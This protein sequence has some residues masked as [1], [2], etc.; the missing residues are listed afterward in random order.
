MTKPKLIVPKH[1]WDGAQAEK[2]KN[3]LEKIPQPSGWR[4]VLFPLKLQGKTKGG[5]L[6]TDDTV[7]ESQVTTNICKVLKMGPECYKDKE[8]F[9]SGPWCKEGDWVLITRY[10]GS[11]IRIDG[12]ELRIINDDE[13]LA[14][15]DDPRDILPANIM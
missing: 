1:V 15:V 12:G 4:I 8:K 10:A 11:R 7:T 14:V 2:K 9:P 6:L 13:I 5:V 3:E